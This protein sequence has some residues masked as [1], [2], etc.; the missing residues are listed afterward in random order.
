MDLLE[1]T[2]TKFL[3]CFGPAQSI[4]QTLILAF[5]LYS[6]HA[7]KS[8]KHKKRQAPERLSFQIIA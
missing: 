7:Q 4:A 8:E 1:F 2:A 3:D 6:L 5:R